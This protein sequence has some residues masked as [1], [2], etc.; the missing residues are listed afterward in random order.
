MLELILC[1][2]GDNTF[3]IKDAPNENY[4]QLHHQECISHNK[5]YAVQTVRKTNN[6]EK[7]G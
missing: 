4:I 5:E 1:Y 7:K 3:Q 2:F 6:K